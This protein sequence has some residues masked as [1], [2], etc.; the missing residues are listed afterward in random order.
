MVQ[1]TGSITGS[2]ALVRLVELGSQ[3]VMGRGQG[4]GRVIVLDR[5]T[6]HRFTME[7]QHSM[8]PS[9]SDVLVYGF[10]SFSGALVTIRRMYSCHSFSGILGLWI[11]Q[12]CQREELVKLQMGVW[13]CLESV[14]IELKVHHCVT[15]RIVRVEQRATIHGWRKKILGIWKAQNSEGARQPRGTELELRVSLRATLK[16]N[17]ASP[18]FQ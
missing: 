14:N 5:A 1:P 7:D 11:R 2:S 12:R 17:L 10:H 6:P 15:L 16:G 18:Q 3:S 13:K 9:A 4:Q 8:E